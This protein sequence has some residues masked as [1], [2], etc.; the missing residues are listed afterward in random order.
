MGNC[1]NYDQFRYECTININGHIDPS[2]RSL[3]DLDPRLRENPLLV[4]PEPL[5]LQLRFALHCPTYIPRFLL[6][7]LS[8]QLFEIV[9]VG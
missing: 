3:R 1:Q 2:V 6:D 7:G 9:V 4:S 5:A 8:S